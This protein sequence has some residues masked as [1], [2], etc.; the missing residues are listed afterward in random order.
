MNRKIIRNKKFNEL[1]KDLIKEDSYTIKDIKM[2]GKSMEYIVEEYLFNTDNAKL[3]FSS[4]RFVTRVTNQ[5]CDGL[6]NQYDFYETKNSL[7]VLLCSGWRHESS[8]FKTF[9]P[10]GRYAQILSRK[11]LIEKLKECDAPI[12]IIKNYLTTIQ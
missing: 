3:I 2:K 1:K 5:W 10:M 6:D 8:F 9:G 7:Y 12:N 4:E 11:K